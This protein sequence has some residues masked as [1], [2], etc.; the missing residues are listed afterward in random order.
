MTSGTT[1]TWTNSTGV[2]HTVTRC[3]PTGTA[4]PV[5][6]GTGTDAAFGS[7]LL[8][9]G[10]TFSATFQGLGTY[11]YYCQ[12]HG[13]TIM[14]GTVTVVAKLKITTAQL[15]AAKVGMAYSANLTASG[16]VPPYR[17]KI[18]QGTLPAGL[19]LSHSGSLSGTPTKQGQSSFRCPGEDAAQPADTK[20]K[21]LSITV[22]K[23]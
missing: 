22:S 13:Y 8:G 12:V 23:S 16:G 17:W 21:A 1:V 2:S 10:Q 4:C 3:P 14:H 20:S 11:N 9:A 18:S 6:P 19:T 7:G 15:P 5:G